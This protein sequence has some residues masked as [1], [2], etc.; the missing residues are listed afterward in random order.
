MNRKENPEI[1]FK[2]GKFNEFFHFVVNIST[3]CYIDV[4]KQKRKSILLMHGMCRH[5]FIG[6]LIFDIYLFW[7][8]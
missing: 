5:Q 3:F 6:D 8:V 4:N 2:N 7:F 1:F